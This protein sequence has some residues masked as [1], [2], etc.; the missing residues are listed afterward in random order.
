M[1]ATQQAEHTREDL[2]CEHRVFTRI[3]F[4]HA[5]R[6]T[7]DR[8]ESGIAAVRDVSRT[9]VGLSLGSY[10][11]PGPVLRLSFDG[12]LYGSQT[13]EVEGLTIWCRPDPQNRE[14]FVG[15]FSIVHGERRTLG[16]M[17]EVFYAALRRYAEAYC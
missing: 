14:A 1:L 2:P 11:R 3:P 4:A 7:T 12:I 17:S 10:F 6:W 5:V 16:A 8:G 15:G 13:V 9:G